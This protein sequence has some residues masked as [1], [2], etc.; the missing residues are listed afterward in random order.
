MIIF[1]YEI[2]NQCVHVENKVCNSYEMCISNWPINWHSSILTDLPLVVM[3][4]DPITILI[5]C[6]CP[7]KIVWELIHFRNKFGV[8][9]SSWWRQKGILVV[10]KELNCLNKSIEGF[11]F[12][13]WNLL[14]FVLWMLY[15]F[16]VIRNLKKSV[17]VFHYIQF[18]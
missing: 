10:Y 14:T 7:F 2:S 13:C 3:T 5:L 17:T 9:I 18:S 11:F 1:P 12:S 4:N 6:C 8:F 15:Y 16:I